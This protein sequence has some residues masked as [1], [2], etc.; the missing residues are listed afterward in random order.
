MESSQRQGHQ[1]LMEHRDHEGERDDVD[2]QE[3][4]ALQDPSA[5]SDHLQDP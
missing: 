5:M 2:N 1:E 4:Q 3:D